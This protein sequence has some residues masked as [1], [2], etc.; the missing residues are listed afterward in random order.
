MA[1]DVAVSL[2]DEGP[3][4]PHWRGSVEEFDLIDLTQMIEAGAEDAELILTYRDE[5][6]RIFFRKGQ[7]CDALFRSRRGLS[8]L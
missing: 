8:A 4:A 6:A 5:T 7:I 3:N 2:P 1:K